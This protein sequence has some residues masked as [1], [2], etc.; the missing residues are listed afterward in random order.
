MEVSAAVVRRRAL[1]HDGAPATTVRSGPA[2]TTGAADDLRRQ[3]VGPALDAGAAARAAGAA[4][5]PTAAAAR[6]P[7][8]HRRA[9]PPPPPV[10]PPPVPP[11][12]P[13]G[14]FVVLAPART[15]T[16]RTSEA[17][18][19]ARSRA[20][21][22]AVYVAVGGVHVA[23]A[24]RRRIVVPSPRSQRTDAGSTPESR[25][26]AVPVSTA[27]VPGSTPR[28]APASTTGGS[29]SPT[30][31]SAVSLALLPARSQA[32]SVTV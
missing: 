20:L 31:T 3:P 5:P 25:S 29:M 21:R 23:H 4:E 16:V 9:P 10:P 11:P 12:P 26:I 14:G 27:A 1:Q 28:S 18:L 15:V 22:I 19:P 7:R 24:E 30:V 17:A 32:V 2:E 6:S 8:R 13:P